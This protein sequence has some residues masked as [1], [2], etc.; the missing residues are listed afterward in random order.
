MQNKLTDDQGSNVCNGK[1]EEVDIGR[2]PHVLIAE[3]DN[4]GGQV[5]THTNQQEDAVDDGQGDQ[6][7]PVHMG[8]TKCGLNIGCYIFFL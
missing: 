7:G 3:D 2:S 8:V 5:A 4:A 1:V 6:G